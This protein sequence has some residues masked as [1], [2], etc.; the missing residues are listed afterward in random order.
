MLA[1]SAAA[2]TLHRCQEA[3]VSLQRLIPVFAIGVFAGVSACADHGS[4]H[5]L[6]AA[7]REAIPDSTSVS[8]AEANMGFYQRKLR[9]KKS[10]APFRISTRPVTVKQYGMCVELGACGS[11]GWKGG[12]CDSA[13][14]G[15]DGRTFDAKDILPDAPVTCVTP[16]QAG[17]FCRWV[18]GRLPTIHE[19]M[20]AARGKEPQ[21]FAWGN[22]PPT[23]DRHWRTAFDGASCCGTSCGTVAPEQL[24]SRSA[25]RS[26][27]GLDLVEA[28][29]GEIVAS[30]PQ[31]LW[32]ACNPPSR[33][34]IVD[35]HVPGAIDSVTAVPGEEYVGAHGA[36]ASSFRCVWEA[37]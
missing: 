16:E 13:E 35:G 23:C 15:L 19:W 32:P 30:D 22:N 5:G 14:R 36:P 31:S 17:Q 10:I 6:P 8:V 9:V 29:H 18:G 7:P 1:P 37:G 4:D 34:C 2:P 12:M 26:P 24:S 11:P 21:R 3:D 27:F 25:G 33:A 20:V 28:T